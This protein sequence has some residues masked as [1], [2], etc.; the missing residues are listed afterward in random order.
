MKRA[1]GGGFALPL[2][3]GAFVL[4]TEAGRQR[5]AGSLR[6]AEPPRRA[7]LQPPTGRDREKRRQREEKKSPPEGT[8]GSWARLCAPGR[9]KGRPQGRRQEKPGRAAATPRGWSHLPCPSMA[10]SGSWVLE[11]RAQRGELK[12]DKAWEGS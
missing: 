10:T 9:R 6:G 7:G 12:K 1:A 4:R 3:S 5:R 8:S 2:R 11:R